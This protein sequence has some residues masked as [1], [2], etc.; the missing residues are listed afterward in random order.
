MRGPSAKHPIE[1]RDAGRIVPLPGVPDTYSLTSS[2]L[3]INLLV[4]PDSGL[5]FSAYNGDEPPQEAAWGILRCH[6]EDNFTGPLAIPLASQPWLGKRVYARRCA[7]LT[8]IDRSSLA[9]RD[10][11]Q[12]GPFL[13][14]HQARSQI[15]TII[16]QRNPMTW[17]PDCQNFHLE[18]WP[19][20]CTLIKVI[21]EDNW[22]AKSRVMITDDY[23]V[24]R[25]FIFEHVISPARFAV[26]VGFSFRDPEDTCGIVKVFELDPGILQVPLWLQDWG[27]P[28]FF[29][30]NWSTEDLERRSAMVS[31]F[32]TD[33][34]LRGIRATLRRGHIMGVPFFIVNVWF[35]QTLVPKLA[36]QVLGHDMPLKS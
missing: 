25:V 23:E 9:N 2:G 24:T 4:S 16:I 35:L 3:R 29:D 28:T 6:Y 21:P 26:V 30:M 13:E 11:F 18:S 1:F 36:Y 12:N 32:R 10:I 34:P 31:S 33:G 17:K 15:Q 20:D 14:E 27:C 8:T 5:L 19:T 22:N 7:A